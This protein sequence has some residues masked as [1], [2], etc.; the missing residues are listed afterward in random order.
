[1]IE[2]KLGLKAVGLCVLVAGLMAVS[3]SAAQ[4]AKWDVWGFASIPAPVVIKEIEK[5]GGSEIKDGSLKTVLLGSEIKFTCTAAEL[6]EVE[7]RVAGELNNG[8]RVKFTGCKTFLNGAEAKKCEAKTEGQ[9]NGTI[10][11]KAIKGQLQ[12]ISTAR[13]TVIQPNEG[14]E[15]LTIATGPFCSFGEE[16]PVNGKVALKDPALE[17]SSLDHLISE[18]PANTKITALGNVAT[19]IGSAKVRLGGVLDDDENWNGLAE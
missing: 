6:I 16:V 13:T 12:L 2:S 10:V 7:L 8:G 9:P 1:M 4:A 15:F 5:L 18:E 3:A 19:L 14:T 11:S 17:T